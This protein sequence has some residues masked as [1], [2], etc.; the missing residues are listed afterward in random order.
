MFCFDAMK[1][2]TSKLF[3]MGLSCSEVQHPPGKAEQV[4]GESLEL[5]W[6]L[7]SKYLSGAGCKEGRVRSGLLS[8][9][10][11]KCASSQFFFFEEPAVGASCKQKFLWGSFFS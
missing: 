3:L 11:L 4:S 7:P 10:G 5:V 2:A 6:P 1:D 9:P 8:G